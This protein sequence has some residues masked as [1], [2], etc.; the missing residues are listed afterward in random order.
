MHYIT[1]EGA[2]MY[3]ERIKQSSKLYAEKPWLKD[4]DDDILKWR[5]GWIKFYD[6][7]EFALPRTR[8]F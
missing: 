5:D 2:S 1:K 3:L 6:R 4:F 7:K 8:P